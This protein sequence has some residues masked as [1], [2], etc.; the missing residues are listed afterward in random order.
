MREVENSASFLC[1]FV[2][3]QIPPLQHTHTHIHSTLV[4][5]PVIEPVTLGADTTLTAARGRT[6]SGCR[7]E[8]RKSEVKRRDA[9]PLPIWDQRRPPFLCGSETDTHLYLLKIHFG[10]LCIL[11][12]TSNSLISII[13]AST[14]CFHNS[15]SE[16]SE[17]HVLCIQSG[18]EANQRTKLQKIGWKEGNAPIIII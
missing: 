17:K 5:F 15:S 7:Q 13:I 9:S 2:N 8:E 12:V 10:C 16:K 1:C 4:T 11:L 18:Y 6:G 14:E 3:R